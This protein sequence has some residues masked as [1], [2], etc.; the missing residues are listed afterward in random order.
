MRD[1]KDQLRKEYEEKEAKIEEQMGVVREELLKACETLG[2]SSFRTEHGQ[3]IRVVKTR[4][5]S[6]D[7]G[8]MHDFIKEH[9]A[10][11]LLERRIHQTNMKQY[12][13]EHPDQLPPGL[14]A[15]SKYEV[16]VRRS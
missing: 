13:E 7:W 12:L 16:T 3:V 8:A 11:D 5:W 15:D 2:A 14:N 6:A 10:L 4:Y 9:D 1:K